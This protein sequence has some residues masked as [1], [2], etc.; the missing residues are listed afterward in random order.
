MISPLRSTAVLHSN[1][2]LIKILSSGGR[3]KACKTQEVSK[4]YKTHE[5]YKIHRPLPKD[6]QAAT[7]PGEEGL[8]NC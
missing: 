3:K 4:T 6:M 5:H 7:I 8:S 1:F 2:L